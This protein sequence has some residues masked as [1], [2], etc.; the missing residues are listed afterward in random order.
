MLKLLDLAEQTRGDNGPQFCSG[1]IVHAHRRYYL[2]SLAE[3]GVRPHIPSKD[4]VFYTGEM[5]W[6]SLM[7]GRD[8]TGTLQ[9]FKQWSEQSHFNLKL[10]SD[11]VAE[12]DRVLP[13]LTQHYQKELGLEMPEARAA[14]KR[15]L[16]ILVDRAAGSSPRDVMHSDSVLVTLV[17]NEQVIPEDI[18]NALAALRLD[19]DLSSEADIYDA[20]IVA[21]LYDRSLA[22]VTLL[23]ENL[24]S[25]LLQQLN[26]DK[27]PLLSFAIGNLQNL[28]YLLDKKTPVNAANGFGK[29]ALFYA[30][31][32][33][34]HAAVRALLRYGANVNQSYKS[35]KE[36]RPDDDE[37]IY[38]GITHTRRTPLMHAAQHSDVEMLKL[39][40]ES[41]AILDSAD[42]Q[43][44][45]ALDYAE[46]VKNKENESFLKSK[47][48]AFGSPIYTSDADP[49]VREQ[50][51]QNVIRVDGFVSKL[52]VVPG[53]PDLLVAAVTPWDTPVVNDKQGLY[54]IS[55]AN[56]K[57]PQVVSIF[58]RVHVNDFALSKDGMRAYVME[59]ARSPTAPKEEF[60]VSVIDISD[61]AQPNLIGRIDGDFMRMHLSPDG[62]WLYLQER[63]LRP[64]FSR[65]LLVY[66]VVADTPTMKCA[67]PFGSA[68][69]S[70]RIFAYSF[71]SSPDGSLLL[72]NNYGSQLLTFEFNDPCAPRNILNLNSDE[73]SGELSL[74]AQKVLIGNRGGELKKIRLGDPL[75]QIASYRGSF[76]TFDVNA[77]RDIT[78]AA[79][80]GDIAV[81]RTGS[82]GQFILSDR[83][84]D[85]APKY[86][87][88]VLTTDNGYLYVGWKDN[89]GIGF[90]P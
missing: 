26:N 42:D 60:G 72:I 51:L 58:P 78:A 24:S 66:S 18:R 82:K 41:G 46:L 2:A 77:V 40:L 81:F 56:P 61:I 45:N 32:S 38:Y 74:Q 23:T 43:G 69:V 11:F 64:E 31:G 8:G 12:F 47:G 34:E 79:I 52:A 29:T 39:L 37:C 16:M 83:F 19:G 14:A 22:I 30:I 9:Y 67:N 10:Y 53:R 25:T 55:I 71:A 65:G 49:A 20:L 88:S 13:Q 70:D 35:N 80:H 86:I 48:L 3:A 6:D 1:S 59:I 85:I 63:T 76:G 68:G 57:H 28:E 73:L 75:Q 15:T 7:R 62:R 33:N 84:R 17:R 54:L 36:L 87:G 4:S 44:F 89:L 5:N 90:I 27:E 21:L 50:K